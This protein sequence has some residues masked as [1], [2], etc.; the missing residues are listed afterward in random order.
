MGLLATLDKEEQAIS[1]E[2]IIILEWMKGMTYEEMKMFNN[3]FPL[4]EKDYRDLQRDWINEEKHLIKNRPGH[5]EEVSSLELCEDIKKYNNG[6][7]FR[8]FYCLKFPEKVVRLG[9]L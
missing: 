5:C 7:R 2:D 9:I 1:R 3:Y 6:L 8:A 4:D